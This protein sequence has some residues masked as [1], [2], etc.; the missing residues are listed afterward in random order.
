MGLAYYASG[1]FYNSYAIQVRDKGDF[2]KAIPLH[3]AAI[4]HLT[5]ARELQ[6]PDAIERLIIV[7]DSLAATIKMKDQQLQQGE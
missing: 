6:Y 2:K 3:N 5:K 1:R 4:D 7:Q